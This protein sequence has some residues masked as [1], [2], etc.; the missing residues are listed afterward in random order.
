MKHRWRTLIALWLMQAAML[1][2][3]AAAWV[4][5]GNSVGRS[6]MDEGI[7]SQDPLGT[8]NPSEM[9]RVMTEPEFALW[10]SVTIVVI[11]GLQALFVSPLARP[12][13][14]SARGLPVLVSLG[15]AGIAMSILVAGIGYSIV[16]LF[17]LYTSWDVPDWILTI[18]FLG[19]VVF[20]QWIIAT[21]LLWS[22][23]RRGS[24]EHVLGRVAAW[25]FTGTI[26]EA[27]AIIPLDVLVRKRE[28]CYCSA[29]TFWT[30]AAC[31]AVGFFALGPAILIPLIARRRRRW[32]QNR[33]DA[34]G[35]SMQG[36]AQAIHRCPECGLG[37][38]QMSK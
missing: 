8:L 35:Y 20:V 17:E 33:C 31:G 13:P 11:T 5:Q 36:I 34:C 19:G 18:Q 16:H 27:A 24:R 37:W 30:L 12:S 1:Y 21:V 23:A 29:G 22:F 25:L 28:S 6:F 15:I 14:R 26:V 4:V 9:A 10:I 7:K 3:L 32:Y 38:K 2:V